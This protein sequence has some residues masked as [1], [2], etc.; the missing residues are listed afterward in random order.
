MAKKKNL[1]KIFE[2]DEIIAGH[3]IKYKTGKKQNPKYDIDQHSLRE[4]A[5]KQFGDVPNPFH[6]TYFKFIY[7]KNWLTESQPFHIFRLAK[8]F[9]AE[10]STSTG[11]ST[12]RQYVM[13]VNDFVGWLDNFRPRINLLSELTEE[14]MTLYVDRAADG[15][16]PGGRAAALRPVKTFLFWADKHPA[17][18]PKWRAPTHK[19]KKLRIDFPEVSVATDD[20]VNAML[21][22]FHGDDYVSLRDRAFFLVLVYTGARAGEIVSMRKQNLDLKNQRVYLHNTKRGKGRYVMFPPIVTKALQD[23]FS[24]ETQKSDYIFLNP[25]TGER[26]TTSGTRGILRRHAKLANIKEPSHHA[27]RRRFVVRLLSDDMQMEVVKNLLGHKS[28]RVIESY[29][30]FSPEQTAKN[31]HRHMGALDP[32]TEE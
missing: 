11:P 28:L 20:E 6:I 17:R 9:L 13:Y 29:A 3:K 26:L 4:S 23:L 14:I 18:P 12:Q 10:K 30:R 15:R 2:A 24:V 31:Y 19:I 22:T 21:K 7:P 16:K 5:E 25:K 27:F 1:I 32:Q 8:E